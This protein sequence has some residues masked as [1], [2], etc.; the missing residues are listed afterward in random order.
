MLPSPT[1]LL[2]NAPFNINE[3]ACDKLIEILAK[4]LDLRDNETAGHSGRVRRY[5]EEIAN[6]MGCSAQ[7]TKQYARAALLHDLGKI[8]IPDAILLKNGKL[9]PEEWRVMETHVWVGFSL[10]RR[11]PFLG[12]IAEIVLS[13]HER[14]DGKG[15]P[16]GLKGEKIP[17]GARIFAVCDTLDAMTSDRP[18][19]RALPFATALQEIRCQSGRQFDPQVVEAFLAIPQTVFRQIMLDEKKHTARVPFDGLVECFEGGRH[20]TLKGIDLSA[21]GLLLEKDEGIPLGKQIHVEFDLPHVARPLRLNAEVVRR[22]VPDRAAIA[23]ISPP[24]EVEETLLQYIGW[25]IKAQFE[26]SSQ[27]PD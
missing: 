4:T 2:A 14:F 25:V 13:H 11:V 7:A 3:S 9:T 6:A 17:L 8:V 15:Y 20:Y 1:Q 16:R 24:P 23:F 22:E 18:Y 27:Q 26:S 12:D 5:S 19:R 10:L 21:G